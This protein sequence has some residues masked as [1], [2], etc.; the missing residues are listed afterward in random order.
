MSELLTS[1]RKPPVPIRAL[2]DARSSPVL[3]ATADFSAVHVRPYQWSPW[4]VETELFPRLS[5]HFCASH[6]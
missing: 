6:L 1:L 3:L 4:V 5:L 2:D